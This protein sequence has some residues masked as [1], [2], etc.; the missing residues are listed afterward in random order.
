[1][2]TDLQMYVL[3]SHKQ[4]HFLLMKPW[5]SQPLST[6]RQIIKGEMDRRKRGKKLQHSTYEGVKQVTADT[7][8]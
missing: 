4:K 1:M 8:K 6:E 2:E 3:P 7:Q 5:E